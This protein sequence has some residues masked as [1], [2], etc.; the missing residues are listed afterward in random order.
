MSSYNY[1]EGHVLCP[2]L[3]HDTHTDM[4]Y[5]APSPSLCGLI[6]RI[7]QCM[8]CIQCAES[9][10]AS[11]LWT[12]EVGLVLFLSLPAMM[13]KFRQLFWGGNGEFFQLVSQQLLVKR[14][15]YVVLHPCT[16]MAPHLAKARPTLVGV[17]NSGRA[18]ISRLYL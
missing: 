9:A 13:T 6:T 16:T 8:S 4:H 11:Q 15:L 10:L 2:T 3:A 12:T 18:V 7:M 5:F 1:T 17:L 14:S